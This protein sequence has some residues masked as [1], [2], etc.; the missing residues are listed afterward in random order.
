[1]KSASDAIQILIKMKIL[2][3]I[4]IKIQIFRKHEFVFYLK[5]PKNQYKNVNFL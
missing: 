3:R 5:S 2:I 1:M 4:Q